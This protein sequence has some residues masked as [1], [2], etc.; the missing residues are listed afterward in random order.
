MKICDK[1][2]EKK[3]DNVKSNFQVYC[4]CEVCG[5]KKQCNQA[6]DAY[7]I[8]KD[9]P[10]EHVKGY[11]PISFGKGYPPDRKEDK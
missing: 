9:S 5:E 1:C 11:A 6:P 3:Y 2:R 4:E 7:M 10:R 8:E